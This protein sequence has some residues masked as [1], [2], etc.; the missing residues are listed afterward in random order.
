MINKSSDY[1]YLY[2]A[3]QLAELAD[4]LVADNP[5]VGA[6]L[7]HEGRIIGEGY[8]RVAGRAHAE[9]N[10]LAS[11]RPADR[12]FIPHSVL[13]VSLEP[14]CIA[15]RSGACTKRI[16]EQKIHTVVIAQ[17]DT[18]T[19]VS[20]RG[21]AQL[22]AAGVT[23]REYPDFAPAAPPNL[24]RRILTTTG[25]PLVELKYARSRDGYLRPADR[26]RDYWITGP[27]SRRLVHRWRTRTSAVL[28][29]GRTVVDDD[30]TLDSRLFPGP[31]PRIVV[32]DPRGVCTGREGLFAR[33]GADVLLLTA[34]PPDWV[35]A[36]PARITPLP[37]PATFGP[38]DLPAVL[39]ELGQR[40][41]S[42]LTVEGG[43]R[44][45]V[46]FVAAG[47][48]DQARVFTGPSTLGNGL[49]APTLV[50]AQLVSAERVGEDRLE[51][52]RSERL[53]HP[54]DA[55]AGFV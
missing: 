48:W 24:P 7:V 23:V 6:V 22:R 10:C 30:P 31:D 47:A 17:R 43:A 11:V 34:A 42:H 27:V 13:Y 9:V 41:I 54:G 55:V 12:E 2:R 50:G 44:V 18:T 37:V 14:C 53:R 45:L 5:R 33:P 36:A 32:L 3:A 25:R 15:G 16:I 20:G 19:G 35:A 21:V 40:G 51:T 8:H 29:G 4:G 39:T 46:W 52:Y 1:P 38:A 28:V 26:K 49:R